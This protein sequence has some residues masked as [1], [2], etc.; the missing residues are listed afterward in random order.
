MKD[1]IIK[2]IAVIQGVIKDNMF[3]VKPV[4]MGGDVDS[5][6]VCFVEIPPGKQSWP[7]HYHDQSEEIFYVVSGQGKLRSCDGEKDIK[8][9]DMICFPTGEKGGHSMHNTSD[10]EMLVYVDFGVKAVKTDI[11]TM[12]DDGVYELIGNHFDWTAV[13]VPKK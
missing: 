7:Y 5:C 11:V 12:P 4:V 9:G 8:A 10:S 1:L 6:E 2:N 13:E 3:T